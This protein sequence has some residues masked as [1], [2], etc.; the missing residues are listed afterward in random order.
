MPLPGQNHRLILLVTLSLTVL[1]SQDGLSQPRNAGRPTTPARATANWPAFRGADGQG[2]SS[3]TGLPLEWNTDSN[4]S[5]RRELPGAG[6]SSPIVF[7][8]RIY[9]TSYSGFFVPGEAGGSQ[10]DLQRHLLCLNRSDGTRRWEKVVPAKL[11]EEDR[12]RDHGFAAST[13]AAD[14]SGVCCFFGKSGVIAFDHDGK[15]IWHADV[16]SGTHNWGSSASPVFH[17]D[18]VYINASVESGTLY[19]LDRKTGEERWRAPDINEAWNSPVL[20]RDVNGSDVLVIA[21]HGSVRG[22]DPASGRLLWTCQTEITWYMVPGLVADDGIVYCLGGR[23]GVASLAVRTGGSGDVTKSHRLWTGLK[24][25]NVTSPLYHDGHL[26]WMNDNLGIAYCADAA[27]GK[28]IYEER[29]NRSGQVYASPILADGRIYYL[30]RE[31]RTFVVAASPEFELLAT[32]DLN[33]GSVF[34]GSFAV[35]NGRLLIRSDKFLYAIGR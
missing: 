31:G 15:Q 22:F 1:T 28:L 18:L 6:A 35:D 29:M 27:S 11:P 26:Y 4:I 25:S 9:V 20:I 5:W 23:S 8:D 3:A 16:G 30:T 19:A 12:I 14:S 33:D 24:G 7:G 10:E 2:T 34:N 17:R 13:P 32:N 21:T